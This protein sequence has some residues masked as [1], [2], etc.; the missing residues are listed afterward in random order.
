MENIS[1]LTSRELDILQLTIKGMTAKEIALD[2]FVSR[3][4]VEFHLNNI[5]L[6]LKVTNKTDMVVKYGGYQAE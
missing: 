6:K 4:T 3:R 2:L 5:Y 1:K